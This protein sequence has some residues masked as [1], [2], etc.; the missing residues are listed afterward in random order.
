MDNLNAEIVIG[1]VQNVDEA[2]NWLG[3]TY[4]YICMLRNP[5]LYGVGYDEREQD[6]LLTQRRYSY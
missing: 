2:V 4:L 1:S 5:T 3:Y 6:M